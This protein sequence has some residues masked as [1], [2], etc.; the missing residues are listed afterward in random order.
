MTR[1]DALKKTVLF[2]SG[3]LTAGWLS[4][5]NAKVPNTNFP[6]QGLHF[7][8]MGDYGSGN[9]RQRAVAQQM[10]AF[11]KKL[12]A[13]LAAVLALGDNFYGKLTP[14]RFKPHFEDMYAPADFDCPFYA[15]LG[16][17][18]YGPGYDSKQGPAKA[19]M[20][21][22][23]AKDNP[24]SRWKMPAKWYAVE[25]PE[26]K[27][28]LVKI[29]FLDGSF[30]EGAMTPREKLDQKRFLE[31]E[32]KKKTS[33]PWLWMVT[34]YPIFTQTSKRSDNAKLIQSWGAHLKA[35]P[36]SL[37]LSG[38]DHNL[39]HLKVDGYKTNFVV[40][41]AGGAEMYE[42][43]PSGRGFSKA[44]LGFNHIHVTTDSVTVQFIDVDGQCLHAYRRSSK[45]KVK[46][47]T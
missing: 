42:V 13:P 30:F 6:E 37:Y 35:N 22:D 17:H 12:N 4:Q 1:R 47:L 29:I 31:A 44:I 3:L 43:T 11:A 33:A 9:D 41:G 21:L 27:K 15:C 2:S 19:Q 16:N 5:A 45:G 24:S 23:Y 39:Q 14:E 26:A 10:A 46:I 32:L 38:H 20:Q 25:L 40:S 18:D 36:F 7:L 8:A 34:H 28:P